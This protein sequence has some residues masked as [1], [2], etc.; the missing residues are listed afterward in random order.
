MCPTPASEDSRGFA[1]V[2][3]TPCSSMCPPWGTRMPASAWIS[4][5]CPLPST[6][7]MP[8]ISPARTSIE[9]PRTAS[10]PRSSRTHRSRTESTVSPGCAAPRSTSSSTS[11]PTISS[12]RLRSLAPSRSIVATFLPRRSTEMRSATSS[13][14][15]SLCVIRMIDVPPRD[16]RAQH[17]E[18]LVDLLRGQHRGRLVEDQDARVAIERLE[19]L[20]A[21]LLADADLLDDRVRVDGQAVAAPTARA[22]A[23]ARWRGRAGRGAAA[24]RRARCSRR[25]TSPGSA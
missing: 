11:R 25:P 15:C 7:A 9:S 3:S 23:R 2:T 18:Q 1:R 21:L 5:L 20:D 14:S 10:S 13:T 17:G 16:E 24:R 4:S 22:R 6:P 8:T 19:D 12:A